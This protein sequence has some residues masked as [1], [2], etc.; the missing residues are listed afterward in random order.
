MAFPPFYI[1]F[2]MRILPSGPSLALSADAHR[3]IINMILYD[4]F[5]YTSIVVMLR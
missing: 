3:P 4:S 2:F 5:Q 1:F